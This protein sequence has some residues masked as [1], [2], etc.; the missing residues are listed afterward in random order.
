MTLA[1][2]RKFDYKLLERIIVQSKEPLF[3]TDNK[4]IVILASPASA[5]ILG[6]PLNELIGADVHNLCKAGYYD[7]S[8]VMEAINKKEDAI[9]IINAKYGKKF[10][11]KSYP[12]FNDNGE[13]EMILTTSFEENLIELLTQIVKT[14]EDFIE[15][16]NRFRKFDNAPDTTGI[17]ARSKIM[18]KILLYAKR[19]AAS[20]STIMLYGESGTG[21]DVLAKY[22]YENSIRRNAPF[23]TINCATIPEHLVESELFGYEK[24]AFTGA[25]NK[26][27]PGLFEMADNGTVF[28]DEIAELPIFLQPKLL[29]ILENSEIRRIGGVTDKKIN[30][31]FA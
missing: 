10:V 14:E 18:K 5:R 1:K 2:K 24:G 8:T 3:V 9:G 11:S 17:I 21:K 25:Q 27:K 29:R 28:L 26:G 22:I 6:I 16:P 19:A 15:E 4:G 31:T 12:L 7:R 13:L 30:E 23:V 20:D